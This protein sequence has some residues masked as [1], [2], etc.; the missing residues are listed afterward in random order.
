MGTLMARYS[1]DEQ[2]ASNR[3]LLMTSNRASLQG[4]RTGVQTT[5]RSPRK[6]RSAAI[7]DA[8][9]VKTK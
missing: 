7:S 1:L 6:Y 9:F 4:Q 2:H 5:I 3:T 8:R